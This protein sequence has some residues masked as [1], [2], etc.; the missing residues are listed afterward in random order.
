MRNLLSASLTVV[1]LSVIAAGTVTAAPPEP[2]EWI[3]TPDSVCYS[4]MRD[5]VW[6]SSPG[7]EFYIFEGGGIIDTLADT[8]FGYRW[9]KPG[10]NGPGV[11]Y[12]VVRACNTDGCSENSTQ[13][14]TY[15]LPKPYPVSYLS[16]NTGTESLNVCGY[17]LYEVYWNSVPYASSYRLYEGAWQQDT[18]L[19]EGPDTSVFMWRVPGLDFV[20]YRVETCS[21]RCGCSNMIGGG[22][23]LEIMDCCCQG[24]VGNVRTMPDCDAGGSVDIQ[25]LTRLVDYLFISASELCC[26]EEAN[27]DQ[28]SLQEI[29]IG[30]LTRLIDYLF[31]SYEPL[32]DCQ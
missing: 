2:P 8:T 26:I 14:T 24:T 17:T 16:F 12:H 32:A 20:Y 10:G 11:A 7:A 21:G 3:I 28:D 18:L 5:F 29:D 22:V 1:A 31:I 13:D 25:D 19:Y 30:D 6:S 27:A 9:V 4:D 15:I 23:P